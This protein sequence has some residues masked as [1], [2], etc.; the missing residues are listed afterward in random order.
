MKIK[1]VMLLESDS[2]ND[3]AQILELK[4]E[5]I[6]VGCGRG[7]LEITL[8]QPPSKKAV[9]AKAYCVGRG[10]KVGTSLL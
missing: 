1:G 10:L 4:E 3:I 6:V 8:L 5:S 9:N 7:S 2:H